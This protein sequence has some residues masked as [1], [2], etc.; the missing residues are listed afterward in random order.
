MTVHS[1]NIRKISRK[2]KSQIKNANKRCGSHYIEKC[3]NA[4]RCL[5]IG[6]LFTHREFFL[7]RNRAEW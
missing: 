4:E 7:K 1:Y 2:K 5:F 6:F 3:L